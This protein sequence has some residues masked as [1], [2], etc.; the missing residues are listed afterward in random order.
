MKKFLKGV[1]STAASAIEQT[2]HSL[3][4]DGEETETSDEERQH[5]PDWMA[6]SDDEDAIT[7]NKWWR[8]EDFR[9]RLE[10]HHG[11]LGEAAC[12][13]FDPIQQL[14]AVG[15]RSGV[16]KILGKQQA[17]SLI[18]C[19]PGGEIQR[20]LFVPNRPL[21]IAVYHAGSKCRVY[22][23]QQNQHIGDLDLPR[24]ISLPLS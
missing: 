11:F 1:V 17:E 5:P 16:I 23:I 14:L 3:F 10:L 22:D 7:P 9:P 19:L 2:Q 24:S 20:L 21:L 18:D 12:M 8:D 4:G 13:A 15:N 6:D